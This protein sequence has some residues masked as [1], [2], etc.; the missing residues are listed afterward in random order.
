MLRN[1]QRSD[2][3]LEIGCCL[4]WRGARSCAP[5][6]MRTIDS[7]TL[8]QNRAHPSAL[9]APGSRARVAA[10][11]R[12]HCARHHLRAVSVIEMTLPWPPSVNSY[13]RH[14]TRGKLAGRHLISEEGRRYR[15]LIA[16]LTFVNKLSLNLSGS[17]SVQID[18]FPPDRRRRDLDNI[19][20]ALLD[21][22]TH[23]R[24]I[25]DDSCIDDLRIVRQP[26]RANG[27]IH[28]TISE[29]ET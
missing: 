7:L 25:E 2:S 16:Q 3:P 19:L 20:K 17:L 27:E 11:R 10:R 23:A 14:P 8:E 4:V 21:A 1:A 26:P 18:A 6:G 9:S 12:P 13:W 29:S 15:S 28:L 24:V 22:I 5:A